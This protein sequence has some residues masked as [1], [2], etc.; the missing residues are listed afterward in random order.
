MLE[1]DICHK[2]FKYKI[3]LERHKN[4]K[5]PCN[6]VKE[7]TE[8]KLCN[9]IFPCLA[10]LK[11]H[12]ESNKHKNN[13]NIQIAN[14]INNNN[15]NVINITIN[16]NLTVLKGFSETNINVINL[17]DIESILYYEYKIH[18]TIAEFK[19]NPEYIEYD[20]CFAIDIFKFFIKLFA[21]LN[22]N[23]AYSENHN[24]LIFSFNKSN[25]NFIEYQ[26]LEI[27]NTNNSYYKKYILYDQFITEF[28]NLM[29]KINKKYPNETFDY[30]LNYSEKYKKNLFIP[31]N[32]AKIEIEKELLESYNKFEI[33][34][35][36]EKTED[37]EFQI[38]LMN[39]RNNAFKHI[40]N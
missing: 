4:N 27:D 17:N 39:S 29:K 16:N 33:S 32:Q 6:A 9:I 3:Y 21:K 24:C 18:K 36:R 38:A 26:L 12:K 40:L 7:S 37:E 19:K 2:L 13:Y 31:K 22:F 15:N 5:V 23:L 28:L 1:C 10:K 30:V 8:C 14:T 20:H 34:K 25:S 11:T 35:N